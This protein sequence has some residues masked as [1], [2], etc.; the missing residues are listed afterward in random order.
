V[1]AVEGQSTLPQTVF[2]ST[3]YVFFCLFWGWGLGV[4]WGGGKTGWGGVRGKRGGRTVKEKESLRAC[5]YLYGCRMS[6]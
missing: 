1:L 3:K 5:L 2:N 4:K 6:R